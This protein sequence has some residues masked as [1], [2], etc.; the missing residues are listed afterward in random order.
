MAKRARAPRA[1]RVLSSRRL[2]LWRPFVRWSTTRGAYVLRV[3]GNSYGPVL[4]R[5]GEELQLR[6][7]ENWE[8]P[9]INKLHPEEPTRKVPVE[10][11]DADESPKL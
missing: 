3:V 7:Y 1:R 5:E 2:L 9:P 8:T 4:V 10:G 11:A 6:G